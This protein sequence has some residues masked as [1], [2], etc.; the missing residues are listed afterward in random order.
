MNP[1]IDEL[2]KNYLRDNL[3][4]ANTG[5]TVKVFVELLKVTKKEF[6]LLKVL[7]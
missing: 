4:E 2:E 6:R 7:L 3:P 5:D 1:I